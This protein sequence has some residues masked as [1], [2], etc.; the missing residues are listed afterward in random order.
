MAATASN[1]A[2]VKLSI[3][4]PTYQRCQA[5][6]LT[7]QHLTQQTC[8][9]DEFEVV[10]VDD[11]ST[12]DTA[13]VLADYQNRLP[14]VAL[15]QE[16]GGTSRARNLGIHRA[17]GHF[18]LFMDDDVL[19]PPDFICRHL[20]LLARYPHCLIRGPV[21]NVPEP[22]LAPLPVLARPWRHYSKN[23]L[24]TSNASLARHWL[25]RAGLFDPGFG[26]WEDAE[27]GVRLKRLG[28]RRHFD[29]GTYVYH[30][31]PPLTPE[32][33]LEVARKDGQA[34]AQLYR[35][36]PSLRLWLR[37]GLHW[38]NRWKNRV[39]Q[40]VP[41]LPRSLQNMLQQ[42]Q[43]YLQAGWEELNQ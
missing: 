10:V 42:E 25:L 7:L 2:I 41:G 31:K 21:V 22:L 14:L 24:C 33:R 11:G 4:I 35:R 17:G 13:T 38:V 19:V 23:Y 30:W 43:A 37:S 32:Q 26:R 36:Y 1:G 34:A 16:R 8:P 5:L 28:V 39:L 3:V 6:A 12:D 29:S 15:R 40:S 20:R 18:V 9:F 27:L